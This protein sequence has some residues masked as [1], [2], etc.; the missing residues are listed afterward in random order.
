MRARAEASSAITRSISFRSISGQRVGLPPALGALH[1]ARD[2]LA[3]PLLMLDARGSR[4]VH[5]QAGEDLDGLFDVQLAVGEGGEELLD[6]VVA[7]FFSHGCT[8]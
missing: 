7:G 3:E 4:G 1:D 6:L 8:P 5:R 2:R